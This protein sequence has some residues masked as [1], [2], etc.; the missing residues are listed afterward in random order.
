M[1]ERERAEAL[2][3]AIDEL[4]RGAQ[5]PEPEFHDEELRS[6]LRVAGA[7]LQQSSQAILKAADHETEVW[8]RLVDRLQSTETPQDAGEPR[9]EGDE[10]GGAVAARRQMA[11]EVH[12]LAEKHRDEVWRRVQE[13][14][15]G[16]ARTRKKGIFSF[17]QARTEGDLPPPSRTRLIPTGDSD[18]DSLLRV[19]LSGSTSLREAGERSLGGTQVQLQARMRTDPGRRR[20]P[21]PEAHAPRAPWLRAGAVAVAV[22]IAGVVLGPI[23]FTGLPGSPAA[24]AA[25]YLGQHLGVTETA[26]T[27][28]APG[29]ATTF[30]GQDTTAAEAGALLGLPLVAPAH[31]LGLDLNSQR[32]FAQGITGS[33]S[34][35][36]VASYASADGSST[37]ALYEEAAGGSDFAAPDGTVR[38]VTV[39]GSTA[40]YFE[41][42]WTQSEHGALTWQTTGI[43]TLVFEQEGV[44]FTMTYKGPQI[45]PGDFAAAAT[46]ATAALV[47]S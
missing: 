29:D 6:L 43:Q 10:V 32:Y 22:V 26:A 24:E 20:A 11:E 34:G 4:I 44:R 41:G 16:N 39:A 25:R 31:M 28:P 5:S 15:A 2:A 36:F 8:S 33:E 40:S 7:R 27:P 45:D 47:R 13:R 9:A 30:A 19:A 37:L 38:D 17:L 23:P 3:R 1:N 21:A 14:I 12:Q 42:G 18:L 46:A 35:S